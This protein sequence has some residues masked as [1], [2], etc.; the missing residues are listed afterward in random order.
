MLRAFLFVGLGGAAGSMARYGIGLMIGKFAGQQFPWST[1][2]INLL[3]CSIIG[4]LYGVMQRNSWLT[5]T[6]WLIAATGFCGGFTTFSSFA[7][8]NAVLGK[9][10]LI[11][12][13]FL[14]TLLSVVLGI[15]LCRIA[16]WMVARG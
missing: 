16:V 4:L 3:G 8:E 6:G 13:A 12:T 9:N 11:S 5:E 10:Q 14:Y 7:L 1:F 15:L 2:T